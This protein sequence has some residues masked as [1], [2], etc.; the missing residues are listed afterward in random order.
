MNIVE[1]DLDH[2]MERIRLSRRKVLSFVNERIGSEEFNL[3]LVK[4][5]LALWP[6]LSVRA[7]N[8]KKGKS[9]PRSCLERVR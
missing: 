5:R 2:V 7:S 9:A 8:K 1:E 4:D 3:E 6:Y